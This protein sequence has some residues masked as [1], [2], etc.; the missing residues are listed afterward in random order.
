MK[1]TVSVQ[2]LSA[3]TCW[4]RQILA[5]DMGQRD[6]RQTN[7]FESGV[8]RVF[9]VQTGT[10]D[11]KEKAHTSWRSFFLQNVLD[12]LWQVILLSQ[13]ESLTV[14]FLYQSSDGQGDVLELR[15]FPWSLTCL[16]LSK[17][18]R[19][20]DRQYDSLD[21][22]WTGSATTGILGA[23]DFTLESAVREKVSRRRGQDHNLRVSP[24][25]GS[26]VSTVALLSLSRKG[27]LK[28][29]VNE[30]SLFDVDRQRVVRSE[31]Q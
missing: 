3:N 17:S 6:R 19:R 13:A 25:L 5:S 20:C 16:S 10:E 11:D 18:W 14:D 31:S 28:T 24:L 9:R 4:Q 21:I 12:P 15:I 26:D 1:I 23:E 22:H 29:E 30:L 27:R 8:R 7:T 2:S